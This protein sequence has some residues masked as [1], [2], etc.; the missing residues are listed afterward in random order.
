MAKCHRKQ[1]QEI[2]HVKPHVQ[3]A[4]GSISGDCGLRATLK[5]E[6]ECLKWEKCFGDWVN[7]QKSFVK[8][9]NNWLLR[10]II[11][12]QEETPDGIAPFS[13]GKVGAPGTFIV[14]NDWYQTVERNSESHVSEAIHNFATSLHQLWEKQSVECQLRVR[15]EFLL[16]DYERRTKSFYEE[17]GINSSD[18][19]AAANE[20]A[21]VDEWENLESMKKR[22]EEQ[23]IKHGEATMEANDAASTSLRSGMISIFEALESFCL[24]S[25][26]GYEQIR[27]L[28]M[29]G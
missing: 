21:G 24:E 18:N 16:K 12:K 5:L 11:Q 13:P 19:V 1:L 7:A 29:E 6:R 15:A 22:M 23:R 25:L 8:L 17:R 14:C 10:C 28:K 3:V 27:D 4:S 26:R 20:F 2:M 9:L